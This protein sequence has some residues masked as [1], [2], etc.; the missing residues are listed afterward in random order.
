M[1]TETESR[2]TDAVK[3]AA[4]EPLPEVY[5]AM[6]ATCSDRVSTSLL[7]SSHTDTNLLD[8]FEKLTFRCTWV[9]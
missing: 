4:L 8:K 2:C 9:S 6:G 1:R 3:P 7:F 5:T